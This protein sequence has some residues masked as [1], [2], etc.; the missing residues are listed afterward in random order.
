MELGVFLKLGTINSKAYFIRVYF[1]RQIGKYLGF[2]VFLAKNKGN[3]L[4]PV[5]LFCSGVVQTSPGV[6]IKFPSFQFLFLPL[7]TEGHQFFT[8]QINWWFDQFQDWFLYRT[9][10]CWSYYTFLRQKAESA[11]NF[12]LSS[13]SCTVIQ[14]T[15]PTVQ[16]LSTSRFTSH[17]RFFLV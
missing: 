15:H 14:L 1:L 17:L 13:L 12:I 11:F 8:C 10:G 5:S 2:W 7:N 9:S 6:L 3:D 4:Y 16:V